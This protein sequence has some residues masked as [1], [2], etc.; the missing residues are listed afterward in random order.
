MPGKCAAP[1]APAII[2]V[3]PRCD[4]DAAYSNISSGMRCAD[5][6]RTS[7]GIASSSSVSRAAD[8]VSQSERLPMMIPTIGALPACA[9]A[10]PLRQAQGRLRVITR[11]LAKDEPAMSRFLL[12]IN[13]WPRRSAMY[14]WR[15]FDLDEIGED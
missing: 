12:G 1:P 7:Q 14:M 9:I 5:T 2:A 3:N 13:Y 8:I 15:Q 11:T 10:R 6:T 4:A